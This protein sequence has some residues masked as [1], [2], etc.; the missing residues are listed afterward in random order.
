MTEIEDDVQAGQYARFL[1]RSH[2][3]GDPLIPVSSEG[4]T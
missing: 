2:P 3:L 4:G 1:P